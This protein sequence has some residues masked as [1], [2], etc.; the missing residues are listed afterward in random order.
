MGTTMERVTGI[1]VFS[2]NLLYNT[3]SAM[4]SHNPPALLIVAYLRIDSVREI[5]QKAHQFG[6]DRVYIVIDR[7]KTSE[8][9]LHQNELHRMIETYSSKF[10]VFQTHYR[11][12]NVGCAVSVLTGLDWIFH[13]EEFVC[14]L[15]DDCIPTLD[16][17]EFVISSRRY[18][19]SDVDLMLVCG[20][21]FAPVE[22][23]RNTWLKSNYSLTWGWATTKDKWMKIR[24]DFLNLEIDQRGFRGTSITRLLKNFTNPETIYWISGARRAY[25]G[26]VDVW[27]TILVK[28]LYFS[29][30][31]A[32][33]PGCTLVENIGDDTYATHTRNSTW[34]KLETGH[35]FP[36]DSEPKVNLF[37]NDW[38]KDKFFRIRFRHLITT[39]LTFLLDK[40]HKAH[41]TPL[42]DRWL[43]NQ[44]MDS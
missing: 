13:F 23:T 24:A 44:I 40:F 29:G 25:E 17:F 10:S 1:L 22:I 2:H 15:E 37:V 12:A 39:R 26:Y 11:R 5:L 19:D 7:A 42:I 43:N 36:D 3:F 27:D 31:A 41:R 34:T 38:L 20:T 35:Y 32:L 30:Q 4:K 33:L 16:F 28:N 9:L 8:G 18:L 14:I 6:I 21:Q